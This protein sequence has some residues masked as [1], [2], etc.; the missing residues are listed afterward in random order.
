MKLRYLRTWE[1]EMS[2]RK[3]ICL[4]LFIILSTL[5]LAAC[6]H[7]ATPP[8]FEF[9]TTPTSAD[10]TSGTNTTSA[11]TASET[12]LSPTDTV[13]E[14][15]LSLTDTV[16]ETDLSPTDTVPETDLDTTPPLEYTSGLSFNP[17]KD[18][19]E[20]EVFSIGNVTD[21]SI[22]IPPI[23]EGKPVTAIGEFAFESCSILESVYLPEGITSIGHNAF[24]NCNHLTSIYLP[25]TLTDIG[26]FAFR[27]SAI[28][29]IQ[30]PSNVKSI[31]HHAFQGSRLKTIALPDG[32]EVLGECAFNKCSELESITIPSFMTIIEESAFNSCEML[33][34]VVLHD[35]ITQIGASAFE[36]CSSLI[37]ITL[38]ES[39]T[40][41]GRG[42][43]SECTSLVTKERGITYVGNWIVHVDSSVSSLKVRDG[44]TGIADG[45]CAYNPNINSVELPVSIKHI[46]ESVFEQCNL[47]TEIHYSG[48]AEQW[49]Q[50]NKTLDDYPIS[51]SNGIISNT[52]Y[53]MGL[54]GN[55]PCTV[56]GIGTCPDDEWNSLD[57]SN[58]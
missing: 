7:R 5:L 21:P 58:G 53:R 27:Y 24:A 33:T 46:G 14:T 52:G 6:G 38:P 55:G 1:R 47:L 48:T 43:F 54:L 9:E 28:Q 2:M 56:K 40:S 19:T 39:V 22:V 37:N 45:V 4:M 15:D 31:G 23:Y 10:N 11:D 3:T 34:T 42:A 30:L 57:K 44:I 20:Y 12:D 50:V 8:K 26:D 18:H 36:G 29:T 41:I 17:I 51:F 32:L 13:P 25:S 49:E 16:P 35:T